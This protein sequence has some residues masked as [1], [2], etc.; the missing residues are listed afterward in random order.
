MKVQSPADEF[1][2]LRAVSSG[3][4]LA[5]SI[6]NAELHYGSP[7]VISDLSW[8]RCSLAQAA[9]ETKIPAAPDHRYTSRVY[10]PSSAEECGVSSSRRR[11]RSS[12]WRSV[13]W[14]IQFFIGNDIRYCD[15]WIVIFFSF[16]CK[17]GKIDCLFWTER[18]TGHTLAALM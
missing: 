4:D 10:A 13:V 11:H 3:S 5:R 17:F 9:M 2:P 6:A 15:M 14:R 7:S 8:L 18:N 16:P 12:A 1:N